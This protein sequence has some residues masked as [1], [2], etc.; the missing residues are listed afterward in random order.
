MSY[1]SYHE[2]KERNNE[3]SVFFHSV[4]KDKL[5]ASFVF[6]FSYHKVI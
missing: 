1:Y 5:K 4:V 3:M 6:I 2:T